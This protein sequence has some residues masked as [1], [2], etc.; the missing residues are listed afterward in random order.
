MGFIVFQYSWWLALF[1]FVCGAFSVFK[2]RSWKLAPRILLIG[3]G[4]TVGTSIA[5]VGVF[6]R[7]TQRGEIWAAICFVAAVAYIVMLRKC[8]VRQK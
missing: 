6:H 5:E 4:C 7:G 8:D 3:L 1:V 2:T